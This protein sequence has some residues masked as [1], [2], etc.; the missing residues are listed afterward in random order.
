MPPTQTSSLLIHGVS[1]IAVV[2]SVGSVEWLRHMVF[3]LRVRGDGV[4]RRGNQID[5]YKPSGRSTSRRVADKMVSNRCFEGARWRV[6]VVVAISYVQHLGTIWVW[7]RSCSTYGI[8]RA[9]RTYNIVIRTPKNTS[10]LPSLKICRVHLA[11][12]KLQ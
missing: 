10:R 7:H 2:E 11:D 9:T 1:I 5:I 12:G 4:D 6:G 8:Q 3:W